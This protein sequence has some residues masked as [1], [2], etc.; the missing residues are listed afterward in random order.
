[1]LFTSLPRGWLSARAASAAA[2]STGAGYVPDPA[3]YQGDP[4][5]D[6]TLNRIALTESV[7][8]NP[9]P[10][11]TPGNGGGPCPGKGGPRLRRVTG[12][13]KDG[14]PDKPALIPGR[15]NAPPAARDGRGEAAP[16][17]LALQQLPARR[18]A[19]RG[20]GGNVGPPA[21]RRFE[22]VN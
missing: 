14:R 1:M 21:R 9:L 20:R 13:G 19:P 18:G 2:A 3:T 6:G 16:T 22:S 8:Q 5:I 7:V 17:R 4:M 12:P 11:T 10:Q 15:H